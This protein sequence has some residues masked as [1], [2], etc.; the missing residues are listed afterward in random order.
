MN[1]T[2]SRPNVV[3]IG[4]GFAGRC[5]HAYLVGLA[6]G[7]RLHGVA[8][9]DAETRAR[10]ETD[11][12]GQ[13]V[14][15]YTDLDSVCADP[16][17]DLV[18]LATPTHVHT[19]QAVQCLTAGKHVVVDK[20]TALSLADTDRM[21]AASQSSG[22]LLSI[23]QNRRWDGDY[24]TARR[25]MDSGA[26]GDVRWIE[27]AWQGFGPWGGWRGHAEFGGGRYWDLGAHLA[28]Q[29]CQFFPEPVE[30][31]YCRLRRDYPSH[32]I[33]SEALLVVGFAGGRTGVLDLSGTTA[34]PK[35]RFLLHGSAATFS[36][37]G[38]DPQEE[39]MIA[40]DIDSAVDPQENWA[41]IHDGKSERV[42]ETLPGRWRSYYENIADALSGAAPLAVD[43]ASVRRAM[44]ILDAGIRSSETGSVERLG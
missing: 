37:Y 29:I 30:S 7:L 39:A 42:V 10:I 6:D 32:D 38:L 41:R 23:F 5:F 3:V 11:L 28:D 14:R 43:M 19:D 21:I 9:R 35:P 16:D 8:S 20:P 24:L 12:G 15:A 4:Y 36:K 44:S 1:P 2:N 33:D 25:A 31:V 27:M 17:V 40:G 26:L 22:K 34:H 18:V 13:G